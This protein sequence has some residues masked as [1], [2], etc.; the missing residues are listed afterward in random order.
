[1]K[2]KRC[3]DCAYM[4]LANRDCDF[5]KRSFY[6]NQL[7]YSGSLSDNKDGKCPNYKEV[8]ALRKFYRKIFYSDNVTLT[9]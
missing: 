7:A 2:K 8:G 3:I 5:T 9:F 4:Y 1:M 6:T